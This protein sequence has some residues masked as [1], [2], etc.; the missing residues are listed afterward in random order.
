MEKN[1]FHSV[2]LDKDKCVGCMNCIKRCPTE[3]IRVRNGSATIIKE[4]CID[5]GKCIS[6]CPHHAKYAERDRL[7]DIIKYKYNVAL[8]APSLY[9]QFNNLENIDYVLA[10]LI[11][12]GFDEV[13]EVSHAAEIISQLTRKAINN[14]KTGKPLI[15]SAC[16]AVCR[17]IRVCYPSLLEQLVDI[18]APIEYAAMAARRDAV[19]KTGLSPDEIGIFFITPCPAKITASKNPITL[20]GPIIDGAIAM[21]DIYPVLLQQMN[22]LAKS[23]EA[24]PELHNS[25]RIGIGWGISGGESAGLFET[26]YIAVDGID[27]VKKI[28][29]EIENGKLNNL[30]FIELNSCTGGCVGGVLTVENPFI[31]KRRMQHL[32]YCTQ[33]VAEKYTEDDE[34]NDADIIRWRKIPEPAN[35]MRL[36]D[37]FKDAMRI[38]ND[39]NELE[40]NLPKLDCGTCGAP[41]CKALAEDIVRGFSKPREC[42]F[43]TV[44]K[45]KESHEPQAEMFIQNL[46]ASFKASE[47]EKK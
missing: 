3:A 5:C 22:R 12:M 27:N 33:M 28:L 9:G 41:S 36:A 32:T 47:E 18:N 14:N 23:G 34:K 11:E 8:P 4:K 44:E 43:L 17:L 39:I 45:Y 13:Y 7:Q 1:V 20:D 30:K 26:D 24:I 31:A 21:S 38:M 35:I 15:S 46:P 37:N 29:E 42:I 16:P 2:R 10:G 19:K 6:V 25:G 40:K